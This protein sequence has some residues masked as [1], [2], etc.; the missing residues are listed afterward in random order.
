MKSFNNY[1]KIND[2]QIS[3]EIHNNDKY[4]LIL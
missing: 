3:F 2:N 1:N 4:K